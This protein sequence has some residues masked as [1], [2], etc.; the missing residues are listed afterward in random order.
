MSRTVFLIFGPWLQ[1]PESYDSASH[2]LYRYWWQTKNHYY[3][4]FSCEIEWRSCTVRFKYFQIKF[5]KLL[6]KFLHFE[7]LSAS[8]STVKYCSYSFL[9]GFKGLQWLWS[10]GLVIWPYIGVRIISLYP[11]TWLGDGRCLASGA[12]NDNIFFITKVNIELY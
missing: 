8:N 11:I 10:F 7:N 12:D 4:W 6:A 5:K 2:S 1:N 9:N 3:T